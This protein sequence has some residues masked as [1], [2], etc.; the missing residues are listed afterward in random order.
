MK[1][2]RILAVAMAIIATQGLRAEA[3]KPFFTEKGVIQVG[4]NVLLCGRLTITPIP[5]A[6]LDPLIP[7]DR[8]FNEIW[9]KAVNYTWT[10]DRVTLGS[11]KLPI[12]GQSFSYGHAGVGDAPHFDIIVYTKDR[13]G[14]EIPL[15]ARQYVTIESN[16]HHGS[17]LSGH[18][19]E[20]WEPLN[21][22][23]K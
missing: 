10:G 21:M 17:C 2:L 22:I 18:V 3:P 11:A 16:Y 12:E 4:D 1:N 8:Q 19:P 9:V 7:V 14:N 6:K 20:H 23:G 15:D 5:I 13:Q